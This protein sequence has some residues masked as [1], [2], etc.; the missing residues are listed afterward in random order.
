MKRAQ[1]SL[2]Y[3][4]GGMRLDDYPEGSGAHDL[5]LRCCGYIPRNKNWNFS[6]VFSSYWR[7]YYNFSSGHHITHN[8]RAVALHPG[9]FVLIPENVL[10]H[11]HSPAGTP[12]HLYIHFNLLPGRAPLLNAPIVVRTDALGRAA[13]RKLSRA[14]L[15]SGPD[16]VGHLAAS[17]VHGVLGSLAV[18]HSIAPLASL[19]LRK[20]LAFVADHL[21]EDLSNPA[22]ARAAGT[23]VRGLIRLFERELHASPQ[24]YVRQIRMQEAARR[25]AQGQDTIDQ[26]ADELGF[27]NRFYF[28][29]RFTSHLGCPPGEFRRRVRGKQS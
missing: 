27:P 20:A 26:I 22:L 23:S 12:S 1:D 28:T 10:F 3:V 25:L 17:L 21:S 18:K 13:A 7:L 15:K 8:D 24:S 14:V 5:I 6:Q 9:R 2:A 16:R 19:P 29:R 4:P 11:C